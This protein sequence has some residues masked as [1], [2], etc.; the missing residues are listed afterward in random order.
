MNY[1]EI[2]FEIKDRACHIS[3]NRPEKLNAL[4]QALRDELGMALN[5]METHQEVCVVVIKGTGRAFC[6]GYDITIS[7]AYCALEGRFKILQ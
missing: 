5:E 3:L 2:I 7:N 6:A 4:S 1:R